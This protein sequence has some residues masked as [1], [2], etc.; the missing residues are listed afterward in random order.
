MSRNVRIKI[1]RT[2]ILSVVFVWVWNLV[3]HIIKEEHRLGAFENRE[4]RR[5][6]EPKRRDEMIGGQRKLYNVELRILYSSPHIIRM[7]K[8]GSKKYEMGE[9][10]SEN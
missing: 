3:S 5:M 6:F 4:Q 10:C 9:G 8:S 7:I 2:I 1:Y